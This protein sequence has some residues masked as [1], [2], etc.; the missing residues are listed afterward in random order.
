MENNLSLHIRQFNDRVRIMNQSQ[1]KNLVL[2]AQDARDIQ[3]DIFAVLAQLTALT[4][5][6]TAMQEEIVQI[7]VDGGGF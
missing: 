6:V 7:D 4:Q 3:A 5:H 2:S 1:S